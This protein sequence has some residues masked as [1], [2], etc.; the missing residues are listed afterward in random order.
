MWDLAVYVV[1]LARKPIWSMNADEIKSFYAAQDADAKA[2]P[3]KR[4]AYLV[5]PFQLG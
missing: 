3:V 2:N 1:S 4:G 5:D